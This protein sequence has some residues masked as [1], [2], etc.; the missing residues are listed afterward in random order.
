[1]KCEYEGC[2]ETA[3]LICGC[4]WL[5]CEA[6]QNVNCAH[7]RRDEAEAAILMHQINLQAEA[8]GRFEDVVSPNCFFHGYDTDTSYADEAR[9][10]LERRKLNPR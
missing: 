2:N 10:R 8:E 3:T 5:S 6:H 1:M 9:R 4:G 7:S